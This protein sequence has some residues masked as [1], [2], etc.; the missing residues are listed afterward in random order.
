MHD[1]HSRVNVMIYMVIRSIDIAITLSSIGV[2]DFR[3][4]RA[5]I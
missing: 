4:L 5:L 3:I 2:P 1:Q